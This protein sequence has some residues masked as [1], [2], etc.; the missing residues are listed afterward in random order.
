VGFASQAAWRARQ[1][2]ITAALE[3]FARVTD[4][5][6][7]DVQPRRLAL[8]T[9]PAEMTFADFLRRYPSSEE[10]AV[11]ARINGVAPDARLEVGRKMKRVVGARP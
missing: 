10:D 5:A 2:A 9:L 1:P 8:V 7:L 3:S 6:V 11:V 4:R